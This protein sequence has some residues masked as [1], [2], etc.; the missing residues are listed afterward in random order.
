MIPIEKS[1]NIVSNLAGENRLFSIMLDRTIFDMLS[2]KLYSNKPFAVIRELVCNAIDAN[3]AAGRP[4]NAFTVSFPDMF[5]LNTM[6]VVDDQGPGLSHDDVMKLYTTYFASTKRHTNDFIGG[7]G[8]GSKSPFAVA[9]SFMVESRHA[10]L[11]SKYVCFR[12]AD[13]PKIQHLSTEPL[14]AGLSTGLK[15]SV[16]VLPEYRNVSWE[17]LYNNFMYW[18]PENP[19]GISSKYFYGVLGNWY[20]IRKTNDVEKSLAVR[21]GRI[22][23]Y[24]DLPKDLDGI[25]P[26]LYRDFRNIF[27]RLGM[28]RYQLL[29]DVPIG[30]VSIT[31]SRESL[32][33][34]SVTTKYI[35]ERICQVVEQFFEQFSKDIASQNTFIDAFTIRH[36]FG[37]I[38]FD[39]VKLDYTQGSSRFDLVNVSCIEYVNNNNVKPATFNIYQKRDKCVCELPKTPY[40]LVFC[41]DVEAYSNTYLRTLTKSF[42]SWK[43]FAKSLDG[44]AAFY[45]NAL[46]CNVAKYCEEPIPVFWVSLEEFEKWSSTKRFAYV[47]AA[48]DTLLKISCNLYCN[49]FIGEDFEAVKSFYSNSKYFRVVRLSDLTPRYKAAKQ[50]PIRQLAKKSD[51]LEFKGYRI[52]YQHRLSQQSEAVAA[53]N[54]SE[55]VVVVHSEFPEQKLLRNINP[56][57]YNKLIKLHQLPPNIWHLHGTSAKRFLKAVDKMPSHVHVFSLE[58]FINKF[59]DDFFR[60]FVVRF[61][62]AQTNINVSDL[63]YRFYNSIYFELSQFELDKLCTKL[64]NFKILFEELKKLSDYIECRRLYFTLSNRFAEEVFNRFVKTHPNF[65]TFVDVYLT[66]LRNFVEA[67][68][69]VVEKYPLLR[70]AEQSFQA[71]PKDVIPYLLNC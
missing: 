35:H 71:S 29:I 37:D 41:S 17:T 51:T 15:V 67:K 42:L 50:R 33:F 34:D 58:E 23:Y 14:P 63:T 5:G 60:A 31:P 48:C 38:L 64:P 68:K 11:L 7:F 32:A 19:N 13:A 12:A 2:D 3:V 45:Y 16:P 36:Q 54:L 59:S 25:D 70:Y 61:E 21:V 49:I 62:N 1:S 26:R 46:N 30:S 20:L 8:L 52:F 22:V 44:F 27:Y 69:V 57:I 24:H 56:S 6:F 55:P 66:S 28:Q 10:G 9:D 40:M 53:F 4:W 39:Q 43:K 65:Q 18:Q 47:A